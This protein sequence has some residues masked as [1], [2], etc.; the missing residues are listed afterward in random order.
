L[1]GLSARAQ[2]YADSIV[3]T[4]RSPLLVL[5]SDLIIHPANPAYYAQFNSEAI[6]TEGRAISNVDAGRRN[7]PGLMQALIGVL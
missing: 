3:N 2:S 4:V 6:R 7:L 5:D 1:Q